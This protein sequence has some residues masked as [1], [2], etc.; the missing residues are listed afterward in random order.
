LEKKIR[1]LKLPAYLL[2]ISLG[3]FQVFSL[4][5]QNYFMPTGTGSAT[6][7]TCGGTFF[8]SGGPGANYSSNTNSTQT[9]CTDE[10]GQC[11]TVFFEDF[12][13]SDFNMAG[14]ARDYLEV[15]DGPTNAPGGY[16]FDIVGG[17]FPASF[18]VASTTGCLT[19]QF[20]S[21][22][23][24]IVDLGWR[25]LISCQPCS[26]PAIPS[27]QDCNGSIAVC[28][29]QYYQPN[30]Y[31][32]NNGSDIVPS[33]SCLL[34]GEIN[35]SW[36][37]F[38]AETNGSL[39]F[40]ISPNYSD[41]DYDWAVYNITT[42]G[43]EGISS[44]AS[45]EISCNYSSNTLTWAGQTG[46][47]SGSP[48]SGSGSFAGASG[49]SFN[50]SIPAVAGN[51]YAILVS[52]FSASQGGYYLNL[53]P[54]T[55]SL[56]NISSPSIIEVE[57]VGCLGNQ[58]RVIFSEPLLCNSLQETD[59]L[60]SGP[61]GPY[62]VSAITLIDCSGAAGEFVLEAI[63]TFSPIIIGAGSYSLCITNLSGG[64]EDLCESVT[65]SGCFNFTPFLPLAASAGADVSTCPNSGTVFIGGT[66][67]AT[68][69]AGSYT[70]AWLPTTSIVSGANTANP[71]VGPTV[72]PTVYTV[73]VTDA[74]GCT[75][76]D[77]VSVTVSPLTITTVTYPGA[78]Y[79]KNNT[80]PQVPTI[81]G[82]TGGTYSASPAGL[83]FNTS[84]GAIVP[85]TSTAGTYT[86]TYTVA[87]AG[88]CPSFSVTQTVVINNIPNAPTITPALPCVGPAL[89]FT[90]GNGA[91]YEFTF[92][93]IS[94]G[95]PSSTNTYTSPVLVLGDQI[96]VKSYPVSPFVF[97]GNII[98][99]EWGNPTARST[100]GPPVS[101]FGAGNNLD[102]LYV[103]NANGYLNGAI[104][105]NVVNGSNNR[106]FL[107]ID[108][109]AG[110]FNNL[111]GWTIRTNTPYFSM[112]NLSSSITFDPGFT[113]EY[114][115][116]INQA[117]GDVFFDLYNMSTNF[118]NNIG[119][120][121][122]SPQFG[123]VGNA[124][125]GDFSKGF[126]FAIPLSA[127]GIPSGNLKFFTMMVNDPG[128]GVPTFVS[129][130]FLTPAG[131]LENNYGN[132]FIDFGAAVPN[133]VSYALSADCF[134]ETCV[135]AT[136]PITPTFTQ[137]AAI[138]A[139]ASLSALPTTSTNGI[140]GTWLPALDNS[141][142]TTYTFTPTA[143]LCATTATMTITVNTPTV[144]TFTQ[145][146][147]ICAGSSLSALPTTSDNGVTGTWAPAL[148]NAAT[149][150]YNFTPTAGL[151]A[152][153]ASMTITV[154]APTVPTFTQVAAICAGG[155]LS[156]L[157]TT[158]NN[159]VTGTWAPALSNAATT[160]YNFTPTAGLCATGASMT[161]TVNAPTV[162]TFT[163]V[164]AICAG[165]SLS[166]LPTTS[167]N[168]V[169][170][171]WAPALDNSTTTTY[172][173]TPTAGLCATTATMTIT[174]NTPTVPTFTQVAA[175]CS[176]A[177]LSALPTTSTNGITGTWLPAINN[178]TTTLYTFTP[179]A[180]LC[181]TTATMTIT[182]NTPTVPTFTQVTAICA[183][184]S[185]SALPTT[186]TNGI[187]GTW[188]PA[189]NNTTTTLY[190]FTPTAGLCATTAT[191]TITVNIP[192]VPLFTQ[193]AAICAG[194]A[195]FS[196]P[197]TSTNGI[198]G[199]WA[200]A[201]N[202]TATTMYTFTPTAG[203]CA[204]TANMTITVITPITPTFNALPA[205]C[206]GQTAPLLEGTSTNG[207]SGTWLP[208]A[209]NNSTSA[210]YTFTPIGSQCATTTTLNST[211][212][213]IPITTPIYH[214]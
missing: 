38:T 20:I 92:N 99:P 185:L 11:L 40:Y 32:G 116:G 87:A 143:G 129:N 34:D 36:Y 136:N 149:T 27:Q 95:L 18:P 67:T 43:C 164:A 183:G 146:A 110:G 121:N 2:L 106:I 206:A 134:S 148:N 163:Q 131:P 126:E 29:E 69:G 102:A 42:T 209:V 113:P 108:C 61:G 211:V 117:F 175:I 101:G 157:P 5:A 203:L 85:S 212:N 214:D 133:P 213:P 171:T 153:A 86:I 105:A 124:G 197:T 41:D 169:T 25:A 35:N 181:A 182:V 13:V 135:T 96:C 66:P 70:Y 179:T 176:G 159:G 118:L 122:T 16:L 82:T 8:D 9:F 199:T 196:L 97:D 112:E 188:L 88:I 156:A 65:T 73:T 49:S 187:T 28:E 141:T 91:L 10:P 68:N 130:Q 23:N 74:N 170:G 75:A 94:Q 125:V 191:M 111:G 201:I 172:T 150:T 120:A 178:T 52:N 158:S 160:T 22:G 137:V 151:C 60:L 21:N 103:N 62:T 186:S 45:P 195:L 44:G 15:Y 144:P 161:I 138:C 162:P 127:L 63:L 140:T 24:L 194:D 33:S 77:N 53:A 83:S 84:T 174:V 54:S 190:T 71:I 208:T 155:S 119:T 46:A 198:T 1:D 114:I 205:F 7:I 81:A 58:L 154:N 152:T 93:G 80:T 19:F 142:T 30:G 192:T 57:S 204:T 168:G 202:N 98:E 115:L 48:Y 107:F 89:N 37:V 14:V 64:I 59:F 193:V 39:A 3:F 139:G 128:S 145:V 123:F 109:Q 147:A 132:G 4:K 6:D 12:A 31:L 17:P 51:T 177:S 180:G 167:T 207:I 56:F 173:F 189:I 210:T 90:A 200:P 50:A 100:G 184:A 26:E 165:G 104:A 72:S 76:T 47:N 79:C 166:A 78:P 55:Q